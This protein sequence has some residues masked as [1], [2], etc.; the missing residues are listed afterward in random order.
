[1]KGKITLAYPTF[2]G[3]EHRFQQTQEALQGS[4]FSM[5]REDGSMSVMDPWGNQFRVVVG[6]YCRDKRGS[7]PRG[8]ELEGLGMCDVTIHVSKGSNMAR[9]G[10][11][12]SQILKAPILDVHTDSCCVSVGPHQTLTFVA[13]DQTEVSHHDL[14]R[15][16][17]EHDKRIFYLVTTD[18]TCPCM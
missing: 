18:R 1:M 5:V 3:L 16:P 6:D 2:E 12:Y 14:R 8:D 10:R 15:Q 11:F 13:V 4:Q 9:I 17:Q 7:Q